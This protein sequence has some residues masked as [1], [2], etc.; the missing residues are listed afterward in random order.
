VV[1]AAEAE[2]TAAGEELDGAELDQLKQAL[3]AA[4]GARG[5]PRG[6]AGMVR[7]LKA[8]QK[9]RATRIKRDSLDRALV[10][11]AAFYR[12][13]LVRQLGA[14]VALVNEEFRAQVDFLAGAGTPEDTLRRIEAVLAAREAVAANV[15]PLLAVEAM[16][17]A[18]R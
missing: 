16:T 12:D 14:D 7:D 6:S 10:D 15:A 1:K 4:P 8:S 17:L 11:L 3:G 9:S 5:A 2:A 18:L 13:V